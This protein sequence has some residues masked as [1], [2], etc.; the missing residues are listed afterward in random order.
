MIKFA[1]APAWTL[2]LAVL[3][4]AGCGDD[5]GG[6]NRCAASSALTVGLAS[7]VSLPAGDCAAYTFTPDQDGDH[8]IYFTAISTGDYATLEFDA[9][10]WLCSGAADQLSCVLLVETGTNTFEN[11]L[12]AGD[13]YDFTLTE[14]SSENT[15]L[16]LQVTFGA[17]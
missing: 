15:T 8:Y 2:L 13:T 1:R 17:L 11:S 16:T 3:L 7:E 14:V 12:T 4:L 9:D 5:S 10:L 6:G